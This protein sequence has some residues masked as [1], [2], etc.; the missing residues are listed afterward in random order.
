MSKKRT[1]LI[2]HLKANDILAVFHY[3]PLHLSE[4][5]KRLG[6]KKGDCPVTE[7]VS[8]RLLRLPFYN[9]M[10]QDE[11]SYIVEIIRKWQL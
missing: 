5:G 10:T 1:F 4:M 11:Q 9:N 6:G 3:L 8:D 2:H 7:A